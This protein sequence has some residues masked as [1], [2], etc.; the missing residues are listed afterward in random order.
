MLLLP[1]TGTAGSNVVFLCFLCLFLR[2]FSFIASLYLSC[3]P[4]ERSRVAWVD[5]EPALLVSYQVLSDASSP[6]VGHSLRTQDGD[7]ARYQTD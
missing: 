5:D 4:S 2:D 1:L 3:C 7:V 6:G